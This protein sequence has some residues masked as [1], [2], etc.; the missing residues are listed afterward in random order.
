MKWDWVY[1]TDDEDEH[2]ASNLVTHLVGELSDV[3]ECMYG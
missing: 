2:E 3:V 1:A